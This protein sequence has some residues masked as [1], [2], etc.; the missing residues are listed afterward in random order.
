MWG[1]A[2][3][4]GLSRSAKY[5]ALGRPLKQRIPSIVDIWKQGEL[6]SPVKVPR[7]LCTKEFYLGDFGLSKKNQRSNHSTRL[8]TYIILFP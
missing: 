1:M 5:K 7:E 8:P 2:S 3:L 6:V 4:D